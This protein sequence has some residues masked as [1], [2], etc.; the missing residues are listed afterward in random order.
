MLGSV[1]PNLFIY[2]EQQNEKLISINRQTY[3]TGNDV[4]F[5][6]PLAQV[7]NALPFQTM[8]SL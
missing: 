1:R 3:E 2:E 7:R 6:Q 4:A 5:K 8:P